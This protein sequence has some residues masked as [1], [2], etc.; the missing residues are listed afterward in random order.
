M[1]HLL[2]CYLTEKGRCALGAGTEGRAQPMRRSWVPGQRTVAA[3]RL[4]TSDNSRE[5]S[6][7]QK[8]SESMFRARFGTFSE[9][10]RG[11][12]PL[13]F[14][15]SVTGL[16]LHCTSYQYSVMCLPI[17]TTAQGQRL[18]P[19]TCSFPALPRTWRVLQKQRER[20]DE[21]MRV[22]GADGSALVCLRAY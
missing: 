7:T 8:Y 18:C 17:D 11:S 13:G 21:C 15:C 3:L 12:N 19:L 10:I 4:L 14:P 20:A 16:D 6:N 2:I 1:K 9:Q 5:R 22:T